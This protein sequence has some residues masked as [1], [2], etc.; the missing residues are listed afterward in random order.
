MER[1]NISIKELSERAHIGVPTLKRYINGLHS[2]SYFPVGKMAIVLDVSSEWLRG[3]DVPMENPH[4]VD[5]IYEPAN[6]IIRKIFEND[7]LEEIVTILTDM[8]TDKLKLV[9]QMI[10]NL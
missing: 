10:K 1:K 7:G 5:S 4:N 3:L 8:P 6:A 9:K 2:P